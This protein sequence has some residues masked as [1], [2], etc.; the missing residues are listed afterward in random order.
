MRNLYTQLG[1][2]DSASENEIHHAISKCKNNALKQDAQRVL[3]NYVS[4]E[5]YDAHH[6]T[7][8]EIAALR[9]AFGLQHSKNWRDAI[10]S[11]YPAHSRTPRL[12]FKSYKNKA[13]VFDK[14]YF[15]LGEIV[16]GNIIIR[17]TIFVFIFFIVWR[18]L[19]DG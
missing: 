17:Y 6:I 3:L 8:K 13:V 11:H 1:I 19:L 4:K 18:L 5:R 9:S 10:A 2:K 16:H 12:L 14:I 15:S 7:L